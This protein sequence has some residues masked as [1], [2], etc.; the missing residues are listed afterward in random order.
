VPALDLALVK[1]NV[2]T[3]SFKVGLDAA[4]QLFVGVVAVAEKDAE[5][6]ESF[7]GGDLAVLW[8]DPERADISE[9]P[10][11]LGAV[12]ATVVLGW[13]SSDRYVSSF[14]SVEHIYILSRF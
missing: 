5:S 14:L 3:A 10:T 7:L 12:P 1:P 6:R 2:V 9:L 4:N 13:V 11:T 8:T